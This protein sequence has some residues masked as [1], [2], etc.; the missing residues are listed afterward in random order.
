M[1]FLKN[2]LRKYLKEYIDCQQF[3]QQFCI[4]VKFQFLKTS[5]IH[6]L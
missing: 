5:S 2:T 3:Q 1:E 6:L 4:L